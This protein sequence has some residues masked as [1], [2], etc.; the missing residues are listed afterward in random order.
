M[1]LYGACAYNH[2][3]QRAACLSPSLWV[4][5]NKAMQM[6]VK[7]NVR[8]DTCIY[9]DYGSEEL[10]NHYASSG[11]LLSAANLLLAKQVKL[12][13]RIVPDGTHSEASWEKQIPIFMECL[14]L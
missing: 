10:D 3:F 8:Q 6:I 13:L 4:D 12:T 14:G 9:M 7:A 1:A 5:A 11:A 2:I